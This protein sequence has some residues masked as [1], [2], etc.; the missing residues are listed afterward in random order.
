[1]RDLGSGREVVSQVV[2]NDGN[3]TMDEL[4]FQTSFGPSESKRFAIEAAAAAKPEKVRVYASHRIRATTSP[5]R[6]T[7]SRIASTVRDCGRS[8]RC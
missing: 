3:G 6:T 5:G 7:A 1:M 2:D 4:I 8:T